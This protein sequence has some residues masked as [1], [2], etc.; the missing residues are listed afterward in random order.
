MTMTPQPRPSNAFE[1][2]D[3]EALENVIS[4]L[5]CSY[6][7]TR[8]RSVAGYVVR[9]ARALCRHPG[10]AGSEEARC[11]WH[12]LAEQWRRLAVVPEDGQGA[13]ARAM[14]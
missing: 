5:I 14:A 8:S 10:F 3:P 13:A 12:R 1:S 9:Y 7:H 4:A 11:A 2:L 6:Q